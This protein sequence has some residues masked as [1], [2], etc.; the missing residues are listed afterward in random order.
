LHDSMISV[1]PAL[2]SNLQGS[3]VTRSNT[4]HVENTASSPINEAYINHTRFGKGEKDRGRLNLQ[5]ASDEQ[6]WRLTDGQADGGTMAGQRPFGFNFFGNHNHQ[7]HLHHHQGGQQNHGSGDGTS[8]PADVPEPGSNP[9][10]NP[11]EDS[12]L[13][14]FYSNTT[15]QQQV[16]FGGQGQAQRQQQMAAALARGGTPTGEPHTPEQGF[17]WLMSEPPPVVHDINTASM[18]VGTGNGS[19]HHHGAHGHV[20]TPLSAHSLLDYGFPNQNQNGGMGLSTDEMLGAA[21]LSQPVHNQIQHG[22]H[23]MSPPLP[24]QS[25][26]QRVFHSPQQHVS[27]S[28]TASPASVIAPIHTQAALDD[29]AANTSPMSALQSSALMNL[30]PRLDT[31][32]ET[33]SHNQGNIHFAVPQTAPVLSRHVHNGRHALSATT[34]NPNPR[35]YDFGTDSS[36]DASGFKPSSEHERHGF[37]EDRLTS[38]LKLMKPINRTPDP[39]VPPSPAFMNVA[40]GMP[41]VGINMSGMKRGRDDDDDDD[42]EPA[43]RMRGGSPSRKGRQRRSSA[44]GAPLTKRHKRGSSNEDKMAKDAAGGR[45]DPLNDEQK[46]QNH[47]ASE[48]KRRNQIREGFEELNKMVPDLREG[49]FSKSAVLVEVAGFAEKL[50]GC[51]G[52]LRRRLGLPPSENVFKNGENGVPK[53]EDND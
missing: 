1:S 14:Q 20:T 18:P 11:R 3:Q 8:S 5:Y 36:F 21:I 10:L 7:H 9:L 4:E 24:Q 40:P 30:I 2:H 34:R 41:S 13:S 26:Q 51:V 19:I 25:Q 46:R 22:G 16:D 32:A 50:V 38:E 47:I 37:R 23:F 45:R 35:L 42:D 15:Q 43:K 27:M 49:G 48:Q 12:F 28:S 6:D 39:S 29:I 52:E 33:L 17:S 53:E 44:P 31:S